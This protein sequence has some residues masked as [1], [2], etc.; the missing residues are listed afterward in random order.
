MG[1]LAGARGCFERAIEICEASPGL[2][3]PMLATA[4]NNLAFVLWEMGDLS[5]A[6]AS[7][8]RAVEISVALQGAGGPMASTYA[9]NL[10]LVDEEMMGAGIEGIGSGE[11]HGEEDGEEHGRSEA[12]PRR[13]DGP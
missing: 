9:E 3:D 1:D 6:R 11:E 7:F 10:R 8:E 13:G 2:S 12:Y 5:G 4:S